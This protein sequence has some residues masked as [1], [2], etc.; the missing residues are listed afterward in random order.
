MLAGIARPRHGGVRPV[1]GKQFGRAG[2]L[3]A[4]AADS[5]GAMT[6]LAPRD[7]MTTPLIIGG[8][9]KR[10]PVGNR[11]PLSEPAPFA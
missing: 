7:G 5:A 6:S 2:S 1:R 10:F 3:Q 11:R 9:R 8:S 4:L